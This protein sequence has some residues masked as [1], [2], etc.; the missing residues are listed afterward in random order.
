M[1]KRKYNRGKQ[2]CS[3]SDFEKSDKTF[4]IVYFGITNPRTIHRS[5]LISWQYQL[6][7]KFINYGWM[8]EAEKIIQD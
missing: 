5:F 1:S 2:I 4:F 8:F 3:V 7:T 6:L